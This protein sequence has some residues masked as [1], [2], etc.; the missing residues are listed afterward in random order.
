MLAFFAGLA[1]LWLGYHSA[2]ASAAADY[3]A[4]GVA[5]IDK[6]WLAFDAAADRTVAGEGRAVYEDSAQERW[7]YLY[8]PFALPLTAPLA[9]LGPWPS[10][11]VAM[12]VPMVLTVGAVV[13]LCRAARAR[14][15]QLAGAVGVSIGA[16][17]LFSTVVAGQ[18]SALYLVAV[19][20]WGAAWVRGRSAA[21]GAGLALAWVKPNLGAPLAALAWLQG[22]RSQRCGL[23]WATG[24]LAA[25]G[26]VFGPAAWQAFFTNVATSAGRH[27]G[28]GVPTSK[29]VTVLAWLRLALGDGELTAAGVA[30]WLVGAVPAGVAVVRLWRRPALPEFR[31]RYVGVAVLFAAALNVRLYFYDAL[32]LIAPALAWYLGRSSYGRWRCWAIGGLIA[33]VYLATWAVHVGR[34]VALVGPLCLAW[35]ALELWDLEATSRQL[36]TATVGPAPVLAGTLEG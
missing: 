7:P 30:L 32:I 8:P 34:S 15:H 35:L 13:A 23:A 14:P 33:A 3:R 19:A 16:G 31:L 28:T 17:P 2:Y 22:D 24:A 29:E 5:G 11:V 27:G 1:F 9:A 20:A 4:Q 6:D 26:A 10:Y 18:L 21:G 36:S 12:V 25:G